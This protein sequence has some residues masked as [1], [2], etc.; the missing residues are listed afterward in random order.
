M[1]LKRK[2][3]D[4]LLIWKRESR[5]TLEVTGARQ[6]GKTYIIRKFAEENFRHAVYINMLEDSGNEFLECLRTARKWEPGTERPD[7]PIHRAFSLYSRDFQDDLE[8]V[9]VIDEI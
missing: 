7:Q 2:I 3:Y 6:A 9:V 4:K 5:L 8:T 1:Y